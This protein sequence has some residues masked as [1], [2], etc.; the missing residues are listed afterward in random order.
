MVAGVLFTNVVTGS[1]QPQG[2]FKVHPSEQASMNPELRLLSDGKVNTN[3]FVIL[4][5]E[6]QVSR[7]NLA[8]SQFGLYGA[9]QV[10]LT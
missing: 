5:R 4:F 1:S 9:K 8:K 7:K 6:P 2:S 10:N 3:S